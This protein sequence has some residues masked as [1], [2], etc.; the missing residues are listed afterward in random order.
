[1]FGE[2]FCVELYVTQVNIDN[3]INDLGA[4]LLELGYIYVGAEVA[5]LLHLRLN[6]MIE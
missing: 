5:P 3:L 2:F 4:G 1:M 6:R